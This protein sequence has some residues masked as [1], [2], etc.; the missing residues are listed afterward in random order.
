MRKLLTKLGVRYRVHRK[1]LPGRPDIYVPR[2]RL[3]IFING[4][5]WHGHD[6]PRGRRPSS[7]VQFWDTKIA[8][9]VERDKASASALSDRGIETCVVWTCNIAD[10]DQRAD[11]IAARYKSYP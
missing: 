9:N 1:D 8:G 2:L 10:F 4:C 5:F 3:A 7:N 11:A 6:C